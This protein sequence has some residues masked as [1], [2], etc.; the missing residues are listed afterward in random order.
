MIMNLKIPIFLSYSSDDKKKLEILTKLISDI[1]YFEPVIAPDARTTKYLP[2]KVKSGIIRSDIFI[3]I[4]T[5]YSEFNKW[6][7][8]EIGIAYALDKPIY[9][10]IDE[11]LLK[12]G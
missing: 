1:P 5:K 8:Q 11:N 10:L 4:F 6:V 2:E 9:T 3:V 7:N 12:N